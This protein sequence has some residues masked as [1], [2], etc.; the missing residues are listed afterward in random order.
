MSARWSFVVALVLGLLSPPAVRA[1]DSKFNVVVR[2]KKGEELAVIAVADGGIGKLMGLK[3]G[4]NIVWFHYQ[5]YE[6]KELKSGNKNSPKR[7][8]DVDEFL[9]G[10]PGEYYLEVWRD[11]KNIPI[12]GRVEGKPGDPNRPQQWVRK[13]K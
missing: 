6:G 4:D 11:G 9:L 8:S 5:Y 13:D 1:E 7:P 10:K 12:R 3:P 2:E